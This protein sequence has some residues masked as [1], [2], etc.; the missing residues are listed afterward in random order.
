MSEKTEVRVGYKGLDMDASVRN[1]A[2][3]CTETSRVLQYDYHGEW[4][5]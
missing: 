2:R 1:Q 3:V 5:F 4:I